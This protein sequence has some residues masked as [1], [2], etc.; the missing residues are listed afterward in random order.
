ML[1]AVWMEGELVT[2]RRT[3]VID[4]QYMR[5]V[6]GKP[7]NCDV[8]AYRADMDAWSFPA[9]GRMETW[10]IHRIAVSF[11]RSRLDKTQARPIL[12]QVS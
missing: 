10:G 8:V 4:C 9:L 3:L 1:K 12:E 2:K 6:D 11:Q 5:T 7:G